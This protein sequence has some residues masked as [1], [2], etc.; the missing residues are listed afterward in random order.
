MDVLIGNNKMKT[1]IEERIAKR[2][3]DRENLKAA[4]RVLSVGCSTSEQRAYTHC[5]GRIREII[6]EIEWLGRLTN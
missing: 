3:K 5:E 2:K 6:D 4:L 1:K